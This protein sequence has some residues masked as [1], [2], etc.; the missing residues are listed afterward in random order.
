[1]V[2]LCFSKQLAKPIRFESDSNQIPIPIS[3][4]IPALD[5]AMEWEPFQM[6]MLA[7]SSTR[8]P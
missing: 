3:V 6:E 7:T 1:M 2:Q 5:E 8:A 4:E